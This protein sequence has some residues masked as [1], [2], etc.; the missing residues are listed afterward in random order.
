[1]VAEKNNP[2]TASV[3]HLSIP[4]EIARDKR[5]NKKMA[6]LWA[7]MHYR[8]KIHPDFFEGYVTICNFFGWKQN[9]FRNAIV[10]LEK[11]GYL[12]IIPGKGG[13]GKGKKKGSNHYKTHNPP[14][15]TGSQSSQ[16]VTYKRS[17]KIIRRS[18]CEE[19]FNPKV[20]E[21]LIK[22][23]EEPLIKTIENDE[24]RLINPYEYKK[25]SL[26]ER[27]V[28]ELETS[29]PFSSSSKNLSSVVEKDVI[30]I[31]REITQLGKLW[32]EYRPED[33]P[34]MISIELTKLQN[35]TE[36]K[37]DRA[38]KYFFTNDWWGKRHL[39]IK[40]FI[41]RFTKILAQAEANIPGEILAVENQPWYEDWKKGL[42]A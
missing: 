38:M 18:K 22:T 9:E 10:C 35:Y 13:R 42:K 8:E 1:M 21:P 3:K 25:E 6:Y 23:N 29:V 19:D 32:V 16:R 27:E 12:E 26:K 14:I 30:K 15:K 39:P 36:T 28:K 2:T 37:I 41:N 4:I 24:E 40:T 31:K 5:V 34:N 11:L 20:E 33:D 7:Y 17:Y